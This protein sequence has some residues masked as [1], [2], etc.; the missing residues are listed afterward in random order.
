[1]Q[2]KD[3][4]VDGNCGMGNSGLI[5]VDDIVYHCKEIE[6]LYF[7]NCD[8]SPK[9]MKTLGQV[10]LVFDQRVPN[11]SAINLHKNFV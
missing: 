6:N 11:S 1:M 3:F 4:K 2:L 9:E 5:C 7:Q 10:W 8:I